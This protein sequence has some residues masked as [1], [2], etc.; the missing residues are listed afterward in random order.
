L[1]A[2]VNKLEKLL[3]D[4]EEDKERMQ[5]QIL[6]LTGEVKALRVEVDFLRKENER[7]KN[8]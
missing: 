3:H 5:E 8:K 1:I 7:L 6:S 4:A 2:R